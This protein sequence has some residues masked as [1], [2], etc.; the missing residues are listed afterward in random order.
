MIWV[1]VALRT[2]ALASAIIATLRAGS[3]ATYLLE[4]DTIGIMEGPTIQKNS[5]NETSS[6]LF[7]LSE[8]FRHCVRLSSSP[9]YY[10][11]VQRKQ[12]VL[13]VVEPYPL[14][15]KPY[16]PRKTQTKSDVTTVE[17]IVE[18]TETA[19]VKQIEES[20][21]ITS[22][23]GRQYSTFARTLSAVPS[24]ISYTG[25]YLGMTPQLVSYWTARFWNLKR[26]EPE[27]IELEEDGKYHYYF[28][29]YVMGQRPS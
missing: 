8:A 12:P 26:E 11:N 14:S 25:K 10:E 23:W 7:E 3:R 27:E 22:F 15:P 28:L 17:N 20:K 18:A 13:T 1:D 5:N 19:V 21:A 29:C 9:G 24:S 16:L 2:A 4:H 6:P